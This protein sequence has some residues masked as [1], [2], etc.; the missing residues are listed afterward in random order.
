M[1]IK[2]ILASLLS[3]VAVQGVT[4]GEWCPPCT[5]KCPVEDCCEPSGTI[6]M[7]FE[8]DYIFYGVRLARESIWADVNY[9]FDALPLP[10]TVGVWHLSTLG[11][12]VTSRAFDETD[13]YASVELPSIMGFDASV[14]YTHYFFPTD[15]LPQYAQGGDSTGEIHLNLS[16]ELAFG[17]TGFYRGAYDF[18][19]PSAFAAWPPAGQ[20]QDS[21]AWIHKAGVETEVPLTDCISAVL[22]GGVVYTDNYWHQNVGTTR[23]SGWNNYYLQAALPVS[24]SSCAVVTP[25]VGYSG[26]PDTWVAD[27]V[28]GMGVAGNGGAN[29]NDVLHGGISVTVGF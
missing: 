13:L 4:A 29:A 20:D 23:T 15:R 1:K 10:V 22:S 28:T 25:Y 5:D 8:T 18:N 24:I 9:T 11:S 26:T 19:M 17:V 12:G 27:G 21:G 3:A 14:G 16:R 7:G 6:S 2:T